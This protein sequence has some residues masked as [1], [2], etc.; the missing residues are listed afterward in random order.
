MIDQEIVPIKNNSKTPEVKLKVLITGIT[1]QDGSYLA[2]HLLEL[3]YEVHG[4]MRRSSSFNTGR[5]D[6]IFNE[7][8]LHYGDMTDSLSI[9]NLI[10]KIEPDQ[11]YNLAAQSHVQVSFETPHYTAMADAIGPLNILEAVRQHPKKD[12]IKIYQAS[13]SEMFGSAESPQNEETP[14]EPCSPYGCA[15]LYAY[16]MTKNYRDAYNMFACSGI[17]FNHESPRRGGTFVTRKVTTGVA[18]IYTGNQHIIEIGNLDAKRDW[19][20]ARD[21]AV[22]MHKILM[23]HEPDD[24]VIA[25]GVQHTVRE[26]IEIAFG[27][28]DFNITWWGKGDTERGVDQHG[29]TRVIVNPHYYRPNEVNDL[30]GDPTKAMEKLEWGPS[31]GFEDMIREMVECDIH[32]QRSLTETLRLISEDQI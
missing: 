9:T 27:A 24:Y 11:I 19:G 10:N 15:K 21:F 5:I 28:I 20:H 31:I 3:G 1:G 4:L 18:K 32:D 25:T 30:L 14:F 17:L 26:M 13:T 29:K 6:H 8:Y 12:N 22:S 16:W 2:E 23:H 7:I